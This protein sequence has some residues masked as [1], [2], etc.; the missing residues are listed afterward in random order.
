MTVWEGV[1]VVRLW[2][3]QQLLTLSIR[4]ADSSPASIV[5]LNCSGEQWKLLV[6]S[7]RTVGTLQEEFL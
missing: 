1:D 5:I 7:P 3:V 2:F 6:Q 4:T